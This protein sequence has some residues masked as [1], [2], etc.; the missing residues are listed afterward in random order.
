MLYGVL[1]ELGGSLSTKVL[2]DRVFVEGYGARADA[3]EARD[4]LHRSAFGE[5]LQHFA[6]TYGQLLCGGPRGPTEK[7]TEGRALGEERRDVGLA[8]ERLLDSG[9][10][11]APRGALQ[12]IA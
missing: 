8:R 12:H 2:H 9:E 4:L 5:E 3:Q 6:L 10:K 7:D 1:H 11:L